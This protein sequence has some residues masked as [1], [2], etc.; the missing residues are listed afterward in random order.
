[1]YYFN[2]DTKKFDKLPDS[3]YTVDDEG[4]VTISIVHC[5]DYILLPKMAGK[6]V[7]TELLDQVKVNVSGGILYVGGTISSKKITVIL[8]VTI[9]NTAKVTYTSSNTAVASVSSSGLITGKKSG[10]AVI[11]TLVTLKDGTNKA[12]K[13]NVAVSVPYVMLSAAKSVIYKGKTFTFKANAIGSNSAINWSVSNKR[14]AVIDPRT[15]V[16]K[17]L[18]R[19]RVTVTAYTGSI[20]KSFTVTVK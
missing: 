16:F 6:D 8:P 14:I 1:M 2:P 20:K 12:F 18:R 5:S 4:Y 13:T 10:T 15:G 9:D 17:A 3:E 19:G 11:T 7:T